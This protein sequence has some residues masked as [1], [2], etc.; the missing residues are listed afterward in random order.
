MAK[1]D[2][3]LKTCAV[4]VQAVRVDW[5]TLS[6]GDYGEEYD[7]EGQSY[8]YFQRGDCPRCGAPTLDESG[9][10]SHMDHP[11][12]DPDEV[13][14]GGFEA[15]G[16]LYCAEDLDSD[17][18]PMMNYAYELPY[19]ASY[20]LTEALDKIKDLP[21]CVVQ[22]NEA[23]WLALTGG[24]MD[25]SWEIC[26]AYIALGYLPPTAFAELPAMAGRGTGK[27]DRETIKYCKESFEVVRDR[28]KQAIARMKSIWGTK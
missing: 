7:N 14:E 1:S 15:D 17:G 2:K 10:V 26:E 3:M 6:L 12:L 19:F 25:L 21:L 11:D 9:C 22:W 16:G 23:Y 18:G 4:N 5:D 24:G 13:I 28:A 20:E 27:A 8:N